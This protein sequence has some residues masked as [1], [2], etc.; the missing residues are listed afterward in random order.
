MTLEH[1]TYFDCCSWCSTFFS[2]GN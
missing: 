1:H 2:K